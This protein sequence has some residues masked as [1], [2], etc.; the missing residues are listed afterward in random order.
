MVFSKEVEDNPGDA[1]LKKYKNIKSFYDAII[2]GVLYK[3]RD[4]SNM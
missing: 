4:G 1:V 3:C 2:D